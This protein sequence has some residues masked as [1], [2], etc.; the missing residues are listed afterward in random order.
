MIDILE[1]S[2]SIMDRVHPGAGEV[3]TKQI[4]KARED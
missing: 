4:K 3:I 1:A 2:S